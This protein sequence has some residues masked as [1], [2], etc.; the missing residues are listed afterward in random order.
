MV[1]RYFPIKYS[2]IVPKIEEKRKNSIY[3][4]SLCMSNPMSPLVG[5][6]TRPI[7]FIVESEALALNVF[8]NNVKT[9]NSI[10]ATLAIIIR[11]DSKPSIVFF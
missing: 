9:T 2:N 11:N 3:P 5:R 4:Y 6:S 1:L 8:K 10:M 7:V